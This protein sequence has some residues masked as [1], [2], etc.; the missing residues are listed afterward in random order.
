VAWAMHRRETIRGAR[1]TR[2]GGGPRDRQQIRAVRRG[3]RR[4]ARGEALKPW[5]ARL[6]ACED[7]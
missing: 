7:V 1:L 5:V 2:R 3:E 6:S 4:Q